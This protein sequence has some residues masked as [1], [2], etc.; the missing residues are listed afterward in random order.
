MSLLKAV[1]A[2]L[3]ILP[4][5]ACAST[6]SKL[7][8]IETGMDFKQVEDI[9][10]RPDATQTARKDD[11]VYA[12]YRYNRRTCNPNLSFYETCDFLVIFKNGK[13]IDTITKN[14]QSF[15]PHTDALYLFQPH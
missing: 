13:V 9:V 8:R 6:Q 1:I 14:G 4:L 7:K 11:T 10:G 12:L 3:L 5:C 15:S 2:I